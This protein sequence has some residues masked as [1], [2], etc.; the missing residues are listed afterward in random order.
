[1]EKDGTTTIMPIQSQPVMGLPGTRLTSIISVFVCLNVWVS[2]SMSRQRGWRSDQEKLI[3]EI[4]W[5]AT[6]VKVTGHEALV[7]SIGLRGN[8]ERKALAIHIFHLH[9]PDASPFLI[10]A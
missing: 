3:S 1:V 7:A 10:L 5:E 6:G 2:R 4:L 9:N 8:C